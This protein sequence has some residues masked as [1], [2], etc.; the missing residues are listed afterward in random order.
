MLDVGC[1]MGDV[2]W[3]MWERGDWEMGD[4]EMAAELGTWHLE[5]GTWNPAHETRHFQP[6]IKSFIFHKSDR[7]SV[8]LISQ[9][10]TLE[11]DALLLFLII[12]RI[13]G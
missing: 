12:F 4:W 9:I 5:L 2:G 11:H 10:V 3:A 13:C 1:G 6:N 8:F 7:K